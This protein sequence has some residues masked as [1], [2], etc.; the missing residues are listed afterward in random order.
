MEIKTTF[1][2]DG[3]TFETEQEAM[4]YSYF[5]ERKRKVQKLIKDLFK[6]TSNFYGHGPDSI[7]EKLVKN[8]E[9]F[10][11]ALDIVEGK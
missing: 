4:D 3:K 5:L 7:A 8:P 9:I 11:E 1:T 6:K 10:Q 2:V